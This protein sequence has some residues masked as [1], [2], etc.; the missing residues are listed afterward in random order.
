MV[1]YRK[2]GVGRYPG[3]L[4]T[5]ERLRRL[6]QRQTRTTSAGSAGRTTI[7]RTKSA[8]RPSD[9]A[10]SSALTP[11]CCRRVMGS[12]ASFITQ[13]VAVWDGCRIGRAA[14]CTGPSS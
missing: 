2:F 5:V 4:P 7:G 13:G 1:G 3:A 14:R 8:R 9:A 12:T 10:L 6:A 11:T